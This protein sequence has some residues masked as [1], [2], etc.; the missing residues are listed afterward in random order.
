VAKNPDLV[1]KLR[2]I[3]TYWIMCGVETNAEATLKEF[4]K[5]TKNQDAYASMK[6]LRD[7]DVFSHAMFVIGTRR[8]THESIE[9]LRQFSLDIEPDFAIYTALTPFP[10]TIYH[11]TAKENGWIEDTNY[12]NYDMAHAI[13]P[14][15]TL[16]RREVQEELWQCYKFYWGSYKRN[17]SGFFS[18]NKLKRKLYHHMA[19]QHVLTKFRRL[20]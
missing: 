7:N 18:K 6:I 17:I 2:E 20:I 19:G 9:Q 14:T 10:G 3:G 12:S 8:D 16:T 5:G 1:K 11:K 15:E 4:K 13:M